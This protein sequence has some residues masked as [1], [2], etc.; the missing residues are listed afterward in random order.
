ME[1]ATIYNLNYRDKCVYLAC[2]EPI[3]VDLD[4]AETNSEI[5]DLLQRFKCACDCLASQFKHVTC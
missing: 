2:F 3:S 5:Y 4:F 1:I